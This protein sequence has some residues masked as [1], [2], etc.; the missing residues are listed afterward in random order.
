MVHGGGIGGAR[1]RMK[2]DMQTPVHRAAQERLRRPAYTGHT[3]N[4]AVPLT[5]VA[6]YTPGVSAVSTSSASSSSPPSP[7]ADS[8]NLPA[9]D[10]DRRGL[11]RLALAAVDRSAADAS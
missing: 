4:V 3:S 8:R 5:S 7:T 10:V 6:T 9:R 11:T 2:F 1:D